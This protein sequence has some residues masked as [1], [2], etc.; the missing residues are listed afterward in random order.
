MYLKISLYM[1]VFVYSK[2][3]AFLLHWIVELFTQKVCFVVV[4]VVFY[5]W[6]KD[7]LFFNTETQLRTG[8][9]KSVR[10]SFIIGKKSDG[11]EEKIKEKYLLRKTVNCNDVKSLFTINIKLFK[12][13]VEGIYPS[14]RSILKNS[15][16]FYSEIEN[17]VLQSR[18]K[19]AS[20]A[21]VMHSKSQRFFVG[22]WKLFTKTIC[23]T[24]VTHR[25]FGSCYQQFYNGCTR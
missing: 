7:G 21:I 24:L 6:K 5:F 19:S 12:H 20:H 23:V 15:S 18:K 11:N 16:M 3:F 8:E 1:F 22:T 4:V 14:K 13:V 17:N 9:K 2:I 25:Q 10:K